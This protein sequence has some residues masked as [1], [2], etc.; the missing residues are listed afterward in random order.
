MRKQ[1]KR[2]GRERERER[3]RDLRRP[4]ASRI[5]MQQTAYTGHAEANNTT[6]GKAPSCKL[7]GIL[8]RITYRA[9]L[10]DTV[11]DS[12]HGAS[13]YTAR[14]ARVVTRRILHR[15]YHQCGNTDTYFFSLSFSL[16]PPSISCL[17]LHP[18]SRCIG[19][20]QSTH[21][22]ATLP[23]LNPPSPLPPPPHRRLRSQPPPAANPISLLLST[24][25]CFARTRN[26]FF[27]YPSKF[28]RFHLAVIL[29]ATIIIR[30]PYFLRENKPENFRTF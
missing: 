18:T 24:V 26:T 11:R 5:D 29:R 25:T 6:T 7:F 10:F 19:T 12:L 13:A 9:V 1:K 23:M 20:E 16:P 27:S 30:W 22:S 8:G 2:K 15:M 28:I 21:P 17:P 3:E 4:S 14:R